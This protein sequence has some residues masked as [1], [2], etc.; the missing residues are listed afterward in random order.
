M[1]ILK[2]SVL[3][4][5]VLFAIGCSIALYESLHLEAIQKIEKAERFE[6]LAERTAK[7]LIQRLQIYEYGLRGTRGAVITAGSDGITREKFRAYSASRELEREFPGSRGYGFIRRVDPEDEAE[8]LRAARADGKPAFRIRQLSPHSGERLVIQYIEPEANNREAVG[9]DIASENNRRTAAMAAIHDDTPTLTHPITLVQTSGK[10]GRGFLFLIPI[11]HP[12]MPVESPEERM[13]ASYGLAYTPLLID[14][15]LADFDFHS[16]EFS[17]A[18]DDS[19]AASAPDRFYASEGADEPVLD[20]L[21]QHISILL[22]GREWQVQVKA[23]PPF[24]AGLNHQDPRQVAWK[25]VLGTA[26]LSGLLFLMVQIVVQRRQTA[27]DHAKLAAIVENASDAI[28]G[29]DLKGSVISWNQAA[30]RIFGYTA[31]ET[32]GQTLYSLTVPQPLQDQEKDILT[33]VSCGETVPCLI[34]MRHSKN[35]SLVDVSITASPIRS[36]NGQIV[37]VAKIVRDITEETRMAQRF[38]LAVDAAGLGIWV[39]Q[40]QNNQLIWD[41]RMFEL[42]SAPSSLRDTGLYYDYWKSH[43]HPDDLADVEDKLHQH[44]TGKGVYDPIFRIIH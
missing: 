22:Y 6:A 42:Y 32:I 30:E 28:I 16:G 18:L 25:I 17:L 9:L 34:T 41:E 1:N 8:F 3:P 15:V 12:G 13:Q 39:W 14:E 11:Y 29:M 40:L 44:L 27:L 7:Q 5:L 4:S 24:I 33:Q 43:V 19:G 23:R 10:P 37:G 31:T 38:Q 21:I 26:I 36:A 2:R 35:G 20:D